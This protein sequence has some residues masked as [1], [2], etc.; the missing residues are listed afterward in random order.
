MWTNRAAS[1]APVPAAD[2]GGRGHCGGGDEGLFRSWYP[3][4]VLK[5]ETLPSPR[6]A[7]RRV[8]G[9]EKKRAARLALAKSLLEDQRGQAVVM[10]AW[11]GGDFF[12]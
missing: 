5:N 11:G 9:E 2:D 8:E 1:G 7:L 12:C 10:W 3:P 4:A 6:A